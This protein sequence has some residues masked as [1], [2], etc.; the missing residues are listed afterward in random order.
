MCSGAFAAAQQCSRANLTRCLDSVCAI[1]ISSNPAARCQYCG[2]VSAGTPPNTKMKSVS[3]G[4]SAKY[5]IS[6]KDLKKAPT[7]PGERYAWATKQCIAKVSGCTPDDVTEAYD[8]LIEQSC[9]A[10]GVSAQMEK[11]QADLKK[12]RTKSDCESEITAC[13]INASGCTADYR[14][15]KENASF[16]R[17]FASCSALSAGCDNFTSE[18][19]TALLGE[20]DNAVENADLILAKIVGAYQAMR[21]AT[22]SGIKNGCKDN[23]LYDECI[24]TV[25][26]RNMPDKCAAE[27]EQVSAG[28]LCQFHKTAC[29]TLD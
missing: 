13:V 15:C 19:R 29:D 21:D 8:K 2:S 24:E 12:T 27:D 22:L 26:N 17:V 6:D 20:R 28:L 4:A 10:A 16:D 11:L 5:N 7:A 25:C 23:R 3:V 1:N 9:T 18:I 14:A